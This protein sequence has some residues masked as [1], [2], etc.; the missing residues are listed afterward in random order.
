MLQVWVRWGYIP[1]VPSVCGKPKQEHREVWDPMFSQRFDSAIKTDDNFKPTNPDDGNKLLITG[2]ILVEVQFGSKIKN[3]TFFLVPN[4]KQSLIL[5][6]NFWQNDDIK[7]SF[8]PEVRETVSG[9][10]NTMEEDDQEKHNLNH[11]QNV[12]L[13]KVKLSFCCYTK[14]GLG[15]THLEQHV[16]D[17][18]N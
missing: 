7:I 10:V 17:I 3:M 14:Y 6:Y 16:I 4:L 15:K 8:Q 2:K 11:Q 18:G 12:I 1:Y 5:G 13:E 9:I